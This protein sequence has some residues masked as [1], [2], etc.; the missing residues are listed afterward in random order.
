MLYLK[1]CSTLF[2][3]IQALVWKHHSL[4]LEIWAYRTSKLRHLLLKCLY[5][6]RKVSVMYMCVTGIDLASLY[7][8]S[9]QEL[10]TL[11]E[12]LS[13]PLVF[14]G[15]RVAHLFSFLYCLFCLCAVSCVPRVSLDCPFLI[16]I[17]PSVFANVYIIYDMSWSSSYGS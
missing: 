17:A 13:S 3:S 12:H 4:I 10:L 15:I 14:G 8:I 1:T 6:A 9:K 11:R 16:L 7:D 5:Q 2:Y